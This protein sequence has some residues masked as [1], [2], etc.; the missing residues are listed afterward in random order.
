MGYCAREHGKCSQKRLCIPLGSGCGSQG[1][2]VLKPNKLPGPIGH[3]L[4]LLRE[5]WSLLYL[6]LPSSKNHYKKDP[7]RRAGKMLVTLIF[8]KGNKSVTFTFYVKLYSIQIATFHSL[9]SFSLMDY[10]DPYQDMTKNPKG[11]EDSE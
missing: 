11:K 9:C 2:R 1:M 3:H 4:L 7:Y 5:L 10:L 8:K 6:C